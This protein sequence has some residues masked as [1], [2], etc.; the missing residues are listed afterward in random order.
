MISD[1]KFETLI[2]NNK[3]AQRWY[4]QPVSTYKSSIKVYGDYNTT[5]LLR[6]NFAYSMQYIEYLEKQINELKLSD[7]LLTMLYKSYIVT[8]MGIIEALFVNLLH[9]TDNW[10]TTTWE[11]IGSFKSNQKSIIN[12]EIMCETHMFKKTDEYEKRMD[13]D[14]MIKRIEKKHLI[15]INHN[16]FPAL[17]KLRELRNRVH[18]QLGNDAYDHDYNCFGFEQIQMSRRILYAILKSPEFCNDDNAFEFL[19]EI[20]DSNKK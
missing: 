13:L 1:L 9:A 7:V 18:L 14:S 12:E 5:N 16:D 4:P 6:S 15:S 10:N 17:K 11:E 20:Y 19:K 8:A 3:C 2:E